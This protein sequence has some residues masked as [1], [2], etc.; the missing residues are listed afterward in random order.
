MTCEAPQHRYALH[1]GAAAHC[2]GC[3]VQC[4]AAQR[5]EAGAAACQAGDGL[6]KPSGQPDSPEVH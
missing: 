5:A 1:A 4:C 2:G 6:C 3:K